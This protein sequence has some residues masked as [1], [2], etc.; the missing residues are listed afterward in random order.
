MLCHDHAAFAISMYA[1]CCVINATAYI[2]RRNG[3]SR[4]PARL[5]EPQRAS[6]APPEERT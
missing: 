6:E 3:A 1:K 4:S 5:A 2:N